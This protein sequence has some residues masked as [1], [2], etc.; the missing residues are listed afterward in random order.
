MKPFVWSETFRIHAFTCDE[1]GVATLPGILN[2]LQDSAGH[3]AALLGLSVT[4]LMPKGLTWVLSRIHV[5]MDRFPMYGET[6][7]LETWPS[8]VDRFMAL[9]EFELFDAG[10]LRIGGLRTFWVMVDLATMRP[11]ALPDHVHE[12]AGENSRFAL[13]VDLPR[14]P[15]PEGEPVHQIAFPVR[16]SDIDLNR[17][18][19]HVHYAEWALET[20]PAERVEGKRPVMTD[21]V[22]RQETHYGDTVDSRV[23]AISG[24]PDMFLHHMSRR[25]DGKEVFVGL[26]RY[27]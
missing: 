18:V 14:V 16:R 21:L 27:A 3:H 15:K 1:H 7:R 13:P 23:F 17:H 22:F 2:P 4:D 10:N 8:G 6:V 25:S 9:R 19:N 5:V 24:E 11:V 20:V 26:T 12:I